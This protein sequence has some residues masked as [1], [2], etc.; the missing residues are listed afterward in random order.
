MITLALETSTVRGSVAVSDAGKTLFSEAFTA[1][2]SHSSQLFVGVER[3][4]AAVPHCEQIVVGL[5]PGSYSGVRIAISAA[6]G[7]SLGTGAKLL[8]IPSIAAFEREEYFAIGDARRGA[9]YFSHVREGKIFEGPTLLER[10]VLEEKIRAASVSVVA[11]ER[12]ENLAGVE[13]LFPSAENLAHLAEHGCSIIARD[14]L[15]PIYL[16]EPHITQ[17]KPV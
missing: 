15:E 2:R 12:I 5:G 13:L 3:A 6:I 7:I 8:G 9:F 1:D 11:S 4:L 14:R 16:R 17:P 10:A